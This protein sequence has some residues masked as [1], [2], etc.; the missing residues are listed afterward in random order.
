MKELRRHVRRRRN[1]TAGVTKLEA[2][3]PLVEAMDSVRVFKGGGGDFL[4]H[5]AVAPKRMGATGGGGQER[6]ESVSEVCDSRG[7]SLVRVQR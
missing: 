1:V 2:L 7:W 5:S 4:A 6:V 3:Q